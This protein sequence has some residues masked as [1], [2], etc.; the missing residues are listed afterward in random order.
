MFLKDSD[1]V[2]KLN[3][4]IYYNSWIEHFYNLLFH[5]FFFTDTSYELIGFTNEKNILFT[6][7]QPTYVEMIKSTELN[8]VKIFLSA[9]GFINTR[10]NDYLNPD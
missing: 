10:N 9:N 6:V 5:N 8:N 3:D 1:H 2:L 4:A 7:V